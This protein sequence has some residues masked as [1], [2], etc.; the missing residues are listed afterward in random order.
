MYIVLDR[1]YY[2]I[3]IVKSKLLHSRLTSALFGFR[4]VAWVGLVG[5]SPRV[6][7]IDSGREDNEREMQRY[8]DRERERELVCL[9]VVKEIWVKRG[10]GKKIWE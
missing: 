8:F 4:L 1:Y 7:V 5:A 6:N 3:A 9:S 10:K 2:D